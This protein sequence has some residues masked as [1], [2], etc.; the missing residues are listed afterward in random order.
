MT[1]AFPAPPI[2]SMSSLSETAVIGLGNPLLRDEGIGIV[3]LEELRK[4]GAFSG[5]VEGIDAGT[6]S[7]SI[8]H[9]LPGRK[10]AVFLDCAFM[11]LEPGT[12]AR[13]TPEQ[14]RSANAFSSH[15]FHNGN[16]LQILD[17]AKQL[18]DCPRE[19]VI[20][21]IE[22]QTIGQGQGLSP[23][24]QSKIPQYLEE[25]RKELG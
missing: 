21:G 12:I 17:L 2:F 3:L 19:V 13:F 1:P 14:V 11:G 16:L 24:L 15:S 7:F 18:G 22:P 6:S 10:K 4:E 20:F 8:L 9:L 5:T 25:I 23:L